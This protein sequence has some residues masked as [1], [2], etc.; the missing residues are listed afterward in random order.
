M[1]PGDREPVTPPVPDAVS[2]ASRRPPD[3]DCPWSALAHEQSLTSL[4]PTD[5]QQLKAWVA[6]YGTPQQV[7]L[8]CKIV[9]GA[10][11][12][13]PDAAIAEEL[14][15]NR[16]TVML[17]RNRFAEQGLNGLWEIAPGRGRKPTYS[18]ET[19]ADIVKATLERKP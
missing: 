9:L 4:S 12:G 13:Q 8:R 17:W 16:K 14:S 5:E 10:A 1:N 3:S 11:G 6:A 2:R 7:A 19:V 15:V 18:Q